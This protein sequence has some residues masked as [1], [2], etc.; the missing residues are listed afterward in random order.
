VITFLAKKNPEPGQDAGKE[1]LIL[2]LA[3]Q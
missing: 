1:F 2:L 3:G